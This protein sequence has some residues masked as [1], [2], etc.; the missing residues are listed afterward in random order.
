MAR[1]LTITPNG[2]SAL[3]LTPRPG[4]IKIRPDVNDV[5]GSDQPWCRTGLAWIIEADVTVLST[6]ATFTAL[7]ALMNVT[8]KA[9]DTAV[10][11]ETLQ[12]TTKSLANCTIKVDFSGEGV[13]NCHITATGNVAS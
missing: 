10:A 6:T 3:A 4:T 2:G 13:M 5:G 11:V 1:N 9:A 12:G 8:T 7:V